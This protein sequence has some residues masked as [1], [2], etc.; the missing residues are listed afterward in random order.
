M[1]VDIVT[2]E[3]SPGITAVTLTGRLVLG[4]RLSEVEHAIRERIRQGSRK[5]V[6]DFS[7]L[8]FIDSAAVC[9]LAVCVGSMERE[10]GT[11]VVAGAT[12]RV[13][14]LLELTNLHRIVGMYAEVA[15]GHSALG[16]KM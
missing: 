13:K 5:L 9:M 1:V 14:Q 6:L 7:G 16:G 11:M 2:H 8:D 4:N 12:G 15:S 3:L 10:G